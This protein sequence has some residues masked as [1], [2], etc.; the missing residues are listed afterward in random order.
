MPTASHS[1][2]MLVAARDAFLEVWREDL[3]Y[4]AR[5]WQIRRRMKERR[6]LRE[7]TGRRGVRRG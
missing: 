6:L 4:T 7:Q 3:V 1:R 2:P 5:R